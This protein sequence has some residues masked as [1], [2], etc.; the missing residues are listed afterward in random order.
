MR[1][2]ISILFLITTHFN[3]YSQDLKKDT[4]SGNYINLNLSK[5]HYII[6]E[7]VFVKGFFSID[8]GSQIEL[9]ENGRIVCEGSV[10]MIGVNH[11]IEIYGKIDQPGV[12]LVIKNMDSSKVELSNVIFRNLQLPLLFD[13]GW[14]RNMVTISN[15][16]FLN[17]YGKVS[18]I[19]VLDQPFSV[20]YDSSYSIFNIYD[21]A[22]W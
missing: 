18:V 1:F 12:G 4:I 10:S 7:V 20:S 14:K 19:Q 17:N 9:I 22:S 11:D 15:N 21:F 5:G 3:S 8:P 13:F 2:I 6:K 16:Q